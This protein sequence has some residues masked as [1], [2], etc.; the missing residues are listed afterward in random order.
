ILLSTTGVSITG[1]TIEGNDGPLELRNSNSISMTD[2]T[3]DDDA[4]LLNSSSSVTFSNN[5]MS[6]SSLVLN[7]S[8]SNTI[9]GN[10]MTN[11]SVSLRSSPTNTFTS[12]E[13]SSS[14]KRTFVFEGDEA[15]HDVDIQ[16]SN[17]VGGRAIHYYYNDDAVNLADADLGSVMLAYCEDAI[18]TNTTVTDGDGVWVYQSPRAALQVDVTNSLMGVTVDGGPGVDISDSSI[19]TS[20]RGWYGVRIADFSSGRITDSV[21]TTETAAPA[22]LIED[23]SD[24]NSYNTSFDGSAV[25]AVGGLLSVYNYMYIMVWDDGM[26]APLENVDVLVTEDDVA[27]YS[28]PHFGGTD[29]LTAADGTVNAILLLDREYD[30]SN[31]ATEHDHNVTVWVQIDA[32][33]TESANLVDM[34]GPRHLVFEAADIRAPATPLN[35]AVLDI[36]EQDAIS[37]AWDPNT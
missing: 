18:V 25:D 22:F 28:T 20:A 34:G 8:S 30:H 33:Y 36:P 35:V 11:S 17:T 5:A 13:F 31:T 15:D 14:G 19:N 29:A 27:V 7:A 2:N 26:L 37:A 23:E 24:L 12:N 9:S 21:V 6:N 3:F 10:N 32:V 16:T 1:N 4:V